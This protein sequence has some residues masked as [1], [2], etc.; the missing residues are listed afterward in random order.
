MGSSHALGVPYKVNLGLGTRYTKN[1]N[2][3]GLDGSLIFSTG[4][5]SAKS[6]SVKGFC[7]FYFSPSKAKSSFY[8]GPYVALGKDYPRFYSFSGTLEKFDGASTDLETGFSFGKNM[9][10]KELSGF[11]Q[12]NMRCALLQPKIVYFSE[13]Q[14]SRGQDIMKPREGSYKWD[15]LFPGFFQFDWGFGF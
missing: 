2:M 15:L 7:P 9:G 13:G 1:G 6:L 3:M 8:I 4:L 12:I 14:N 5:L 10:G 11:W